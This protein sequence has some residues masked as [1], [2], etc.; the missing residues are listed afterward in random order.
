MC[1][2]SCVWPLLA[3]MHYP[4]P[5]KTQSGKLSTSFSLSLSKVRSSPCRSDRQWRSTASDPHTLTFTLPTSGLYDCK[6]LNSDQH[7]IVV[8][9]SRC[10]RTPTGNTSCSGMHGPARTH[11]CRAFRQNR[12]KCRETW[13]KKLPPVPA[14]LA[15]SKGEPAVWCH[16]RMPNALP[17]AA[18]SADPRHRRLVTE[19]R[20]RV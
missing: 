16:A 5:I 13:A 17:L 15:A 6:H 20:A 18:S 1:L 8:A 4:K 3:G 12:P 2:R 19:A 9:K 7:E 10:I 11:D 14:A